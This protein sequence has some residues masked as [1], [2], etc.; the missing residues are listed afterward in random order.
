MRH[1]TKMSME[2]L[3]AG[4]DESVFVATSEFETPSSSF[5]FSGRGEKKKECM[6]LGM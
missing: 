1:T 4:P 6:G 2:R 3:L 5:F